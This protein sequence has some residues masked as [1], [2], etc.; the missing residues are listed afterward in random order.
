MQ[1]DLSVLLPAYNEAPSLPEVL[2]EL[3]STLNGA[4]ISFDI[5]VVEDGCSDDSVY[6]LRKYT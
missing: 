2:E 4:G 3:V 6:V 5:V 1:P